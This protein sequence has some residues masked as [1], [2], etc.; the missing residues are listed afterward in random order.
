[1]DAAIQYLVKLWPVGIAIVG[2]IAWL[3]R[4]DNRTNDNAKMIAR[5]EQNG[6]QSLEKLE[7]RFDERR[8]E[9]MAQ[10]REMFGEIKSD[11]RAIRERG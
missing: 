5:V 4:V 10:I 7:A 2:M 8:R 6:A 9:D 11:V 1:M 3:V